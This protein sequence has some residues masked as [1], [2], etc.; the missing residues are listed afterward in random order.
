[1][2][3]ALASVASSSQMWA[4][5]RWPPSG[6]SGCCV[7]DAELRTGASPQDIE[8]A[9]IKQDVAKAKIA[10]RQNGGWLGW[11]AAEQWSAAGLLHIGVARMA[12]ACCCPATSCKLLHGRHWPAERA[13]DPSLSG[14]CS[15]GRDAAGH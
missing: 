10:E 4:E 14:C 9:L 5:R 3:W 11:G 13:A 1:M 6:R 2:Q 12:K 15:A 7:T 8:A